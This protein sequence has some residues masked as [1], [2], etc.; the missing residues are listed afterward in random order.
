[1]NRYQF[2][3]EKLEFTRVRPNI[4]TILKRILWV[5]LGS[6]VLA[7]VYYLIFGMFILSPAERNL[8]R[9]TQLMQ[10]E[11]ERLTNEMNTLNKVVEELE[12]RDRSI[13][14]TVLHSTPLEVTREADISHYRKLLEDPSFA[15]AYHADSVFGG[16]EHR[17]ALVTRALYMAGNEVYGMLDSLKYLPAAFPLRNPPPES[18]GATTGRRIHPF[19]K[20]PME[21]TGMDFLAGLGTDVLA[22]ADGQV[23][24]VSRSA[25][26][27]G[28]VVEIAHPYRGYTTLY[29]HLSDIFVRKGQFVT[30]GMVIARV[31]STGMSFMPHLHYEIRQEDRIADPVHYFFMDVMP[32]E[33][34]QI[35]LTAYNTGQSLD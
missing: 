5:F 14:G 12:M 31:G 2:N 28:N 8:V 7:L 16:L 1:M 23:I 19:Y 4:K 32:G 22:T 33:Y 24:N 11:Y 6:V 21:H 25:R 3:E 30:R 20:I 15:L 17:A 10:T 29:A 26:G 13:Y 18:M 35:M 27:R 34:R 9:E